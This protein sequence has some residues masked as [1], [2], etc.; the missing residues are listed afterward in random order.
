MTSDNTQREVSVDRANGLDRETW[1]Q[2]R[3]T[4]DGVI[5]VERIL[6]VVPFTDTREK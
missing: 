3:R 2:S 4:A 6:S 5:V 1:V